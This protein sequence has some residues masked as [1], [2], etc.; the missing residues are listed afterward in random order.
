MCLRPC[1]SFYAYLP[2]ALRQF[3][4]IF[5]DRF[6]VY[7]HGTF[8]FP[9]SHASCRKYPLKSTDPNPP[10]PSPD[11][12]SRTALVPRLSPQF[13]LFLLLLL[14]SGRPVQSEC[15][16]TLLTSFALVFFAHPCDSLYFFFPLRVVRGFFQMLVPL[17]KCSFL[18]VQCLPVCFTYL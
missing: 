2:L 11:S 16:S 14:S 4:Q 6:F 7:S 1:S 12:D 5:T 9:A 10:L 13:T 18:S 8:S 15:R 17:P 3:C